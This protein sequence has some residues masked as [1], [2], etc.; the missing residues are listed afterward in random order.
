[1]KLEKRKKNKDSDIAH[2]QTSH[3]QRHPDKQMKDLF[4]QHI[5][6]LPYKV[7]ASHSHSSFNAIEQFGLKAANTLK[8][9]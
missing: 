2:I 6:I 3:L 7:S 8:R 9:L 4:N 1:M 5:S